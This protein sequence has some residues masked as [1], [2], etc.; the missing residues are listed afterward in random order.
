MAA[1]QHLPFD[2]AVID[3]AQDI[4]I[5]QLRF[6]VAAMGGERGK[7]LFFTGDLG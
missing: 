6:L 5:A 1:R 7:A 3:E 2:F 4:N